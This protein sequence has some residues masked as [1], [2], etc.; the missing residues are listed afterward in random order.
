MTRVL[1][2]NMHR[3][4][5]ADDLLYQLCHEKQFDLL[6]ISEQYKDKD[7]ACWYPDLTGTAAIWTLDPRKIQVQNHGRGRGF[8][9]IKCKAVTYFSCYFTPN[10]SIQ[11]FRDR[12]DCLE[13]EIVN[14]TGN[15]V[16]A[17]DFNAKAL[18]WGMPRP[19]T[20][21]RLILEMAARTGLLVLNDGIVTTFRRP[22]YAETIPDVSFASETLVPLIQ[23]WSVLEDYSGSDHQY[24]SFEV[25]DRAQQ[26]QHQGKTLRRWNV[27]KMDEAKFHEALSRG[28]E[29]AG[30]PGGNDSTPAETFVSS[31]MSL[32]EMA[33]RASMPQS[34]PRHG[35]RPVY[36]WTPEIAELRGRC[37]RLRRAAQRARRQEDANLRS[38]EHKA[39]RREL[40]RAI[41]HSKAR[42]W[43]RIAEDINSDPWGLGYKIV[44][45]RLGALRPV[46]A[47]DEETA[48]R[49]VATLFPVH[50]EREQLAFVDVE[51]PPLFT[52][53][54]L[55]E[56]VRAMKGKKAPGPDG[57]PTEVLKAVFRYFPHLLLDM[58]NACLTSGVFYTKW[59]VARLVL[60]EK[61]KAD[62]GL[63]SSY[64]PLCMLDT[65]GKLLEGLMRGRLKAAIQAA[66]DLCPRQ[67]GFRKGRSTV[68][69]ILEV[70]EMVRRAEDYNHSSRRVVL[71]VT[72]DVR[73]AF[74]SA[75]WS[76]MMHAL[77]EHFQ[78]PKYLL[79]LL[80]D[81]LKNR[82]LLY[83]TTEGQRR[84]QITAGAAQGSI[85]G[86]DLWNA[87][88]DGL[89][90]LE[91]PEETR[92]VGY[93]DDV[94]ALIAARTVE[95][96]QLK[97]GQVMRRVD[98]WMAAH[99]LTLAL[100][101]TEVVVLTKKR[102]PTILPVRVG[103]EIVVSKPAAKYLGVMIDSKLS[104][105]EQIRQTA[106]KAARGVTALSRLM[107]NVGGPKS[108]KRRLLM[109]AVQSTLLYGAEVWAEALNK[110]S[111]KKRLCQV[112]RRAALRVAS[113][114]RTV[115]EPAALV[116]AGVIPIDLLARERRAIYLR[117]AETDKTA[118]RREERLC[119]LGRWRQRW[120]EE[121]RG[122][123]TARLVNDL[124]PWMDREHGEVGYY[125]TQLLSGHGYFRSY[126]YKMRK[127]S[128][129]ECL[130]CPGQT[131]TAEHTFFACQR[132]A[133]E[134]GTLRV[135]PGGT[136]SPD[137]IVQ[138]MIA[139]EETWNRTVRY[140]EEVLRRKKKDLDELAAADGMVA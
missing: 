54:E 46:R 99:G 82:V 101:K 18:E 87:S 138:G 43:K 25:H 45:Q 60:I 132:W 38:A 31:T 78:V 53:R 47:L 23:G 73:N 15:M 109:A 79:R 96:A 32:I 123:W 13:D 80:D 34:R 19:D 49:V 39:A 120:I 116:I 62:T 77:D 8:V 16:V 130:Y 57:I 126:L 69:A 114:Y 44:T 71:L 50:P 86:P 97:L 137:T 95:Q 119:T 55:E 115:S 67:Y 48:N 70:S 40:R 58:Y 64:R 129:P 102:I 124:G 117:K 131:D 121:S 52:F 125:L 22:G 65:A 6:L 10:E 29:D 72:L 75:R 84:T 140:V 36:W 3:S 106:E 9:W 21:G 92:L 136:V 4:R 107:A 68:D 63:P 74:N 98:R 104:F 91:M 134:R 94:A 127:T 133:P 139:D 33:C 108:S 85:L 20:R 83:S 110:E 28:L 81:Y 17:G 24:I 93:A 30:E 122:R 66:G 5:I 100:S 118:V 61:G 59:K 35:K 42:C 26:Q 90:R 76:D 113:A 128:S 88:Y 56:A 11:D 37:L 105:F 89:L 14:T 112:Q 51:E 135:Q 111:Y 7:P 103:E 2:G 12:L 1:Q 27:A 41:N